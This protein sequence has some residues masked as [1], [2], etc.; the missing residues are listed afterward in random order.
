M[1]PLCLLVG[2]S[3]ST[4]STSSPARPSPVASSSGNLK[5][6]AS[7]KGKVGQ[8]AHRFYM[9]TT[10]PDVCG[11]RQ[12]DLNEK[13]GASASDPGPVVLSFASF[14]CEPCK[15]EL[16]ALR[17]RHA[18]LESL[19]V[20]FAVVVMDAD[21]ASRAQMLSFLNDELRLPFPVIVDPPGQIVTRNYGVSS[22]PHTTLIGRDGRIR[23]V[24]KGYEGEKSIDEMF[25]AIVDGR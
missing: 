9:R 1:L 21:Q 10:N 13:L 14:D 16:R 18:E 6:K 15:K 5:E 12:L 8:T 19:R 22:L 23:W 4:A 7:N 17:S 24:N 25:S 3:G 11:L 2:C 20:T